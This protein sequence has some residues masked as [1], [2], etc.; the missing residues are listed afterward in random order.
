MNDQNHIFTEADFRD[1]ARD[2]ERKYGKNVKY[3][4][5]GVKYETEM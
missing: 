3:F 1:E 5:E 2:F 4:W